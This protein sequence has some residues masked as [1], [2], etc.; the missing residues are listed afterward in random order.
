MKY[1]A[2][3]ITLLSLSACS[4]LS[5]Q[6][7]HVTLT[8]A[9]DTKS[10]TYRDKS[11][12]NEFIVKSLAN[13]MLNNSLHP[14]S[15]K[16]SGKVFIIK[17]IDAFLS[18]GEIMLTYFNGS[19]HMDTGKTYGTKINI[20]FTY[21]FST[22]E[23]SKS[24]TLIPPKHY[25]IIPGRNILML[26]FDP[27][28]SNEQVFEDI[29]KIYR[30]TNLNLLLMSTI[31]GEINSPYPID[32]IKT[33]FERM[34]GHTSNNRFANIFKLPFRKSF[35]PLSIKFYPYQNGSKIS[36]SFNYPYQ[37]N[38]DATNTYNAQ[39]IAQLKSVINNVVNN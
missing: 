27:L 4:S 32:S 2:I 16:R 38:L 5:I 13:Q 19:Q 31:T 26:P 28:L 11:L 6:Q 12:S 29:Q 7:T 18:P 33:N 3:I 22:D 8:G 39:D 10:F 1:T 30:D 37:E 14:K 25:D 20:P 15:R 24:L 36:Y 9:S 17:G 35:I 21:E 34:L 23:N